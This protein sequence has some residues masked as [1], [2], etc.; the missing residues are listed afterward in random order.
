MRSAPRICR[1]CDELIANP[2]DVV[3]VAYEGGNSGPGRA[4]Y[5]HREHASLIEPDPTLVRILARIA[6]RRAGRGDP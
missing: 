6:L 2:E 3:E 1:H 4:V 5:A